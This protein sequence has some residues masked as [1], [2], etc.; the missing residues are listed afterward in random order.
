[1]REELLIETRT[2]GYRGTYYIRNGD[3]R[4]AVLGRLSAWGGRDGYAKRVQGTY[5]WAPKKNE[6]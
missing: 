3:Q 4:V 6:H 2:T 1:M 5:N